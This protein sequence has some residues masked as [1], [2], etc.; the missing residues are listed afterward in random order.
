MLSPEKA[1]DLDRGQRFRR[2]VRAAAALRGIFDNSEL[3]R[4]M[5]VQRGT[6]NGWWTGARIEAESIPRLAEVTGLDA[7]EL[8]RFVYADG[9]PPTLP[10]PA[11][12]PVLE[13]IRRDQ[14]RQ[15]TEAPDAP[16]PPPERRSRGSGA[17]RA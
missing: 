6:V 11:L 9:P 4:R 13:G 8:W 10:D 16:P 3:A 1:A 5:E 14:A 2:Y 12:S 17:G 15:A 7:D